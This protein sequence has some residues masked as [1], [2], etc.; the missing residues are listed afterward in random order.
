MGA[1]GGSRWQYMACVLVLNAGSG[2]QKATLYAI[3]ANLGA[4]SDPLWQAAIN[5]TTPGQPEDKFLAQINSAAGEGV[6]RPERLGR[7]R[8]K[9]RLWPK[10]PGK[11]ASQC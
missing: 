4:P 3:P 10:L 6:A 1:R 11:A 5:S 2:S 7:Y 9:F 8:K